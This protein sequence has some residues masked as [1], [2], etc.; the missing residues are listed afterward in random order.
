MSL[1]RYKR[2]THSWG[3]VPR[4]DSK[5]IDNKVQEM[6]LKRRIEGD[7]GMMI[8]TGAVAPGVSNDGGCIK[9]G[10]C[11]A[12]EAALGGNC[13]RRDCS[14]YK[15]PMHDRAL[16]KAVSKAPRGLRHILVGHRC[17]NYRVMRSQRRYLEGLIDDRDDADDEY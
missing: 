16:H 2:A 15:E 5:R 6:V 13:T 17:W 12:V 11:R 8:A 14:A 4:F 7:V 1:S 3:S 10:C 9:M